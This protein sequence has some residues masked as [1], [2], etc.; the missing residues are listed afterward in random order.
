[1]LLLK[2]LLN[3][4]NGIVGNKV[5]HSSACFIEQLKQLSRWSF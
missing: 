5:G 2:W 1:M 4:V 3:C